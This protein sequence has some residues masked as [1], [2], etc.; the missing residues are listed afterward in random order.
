[1][2]SDAPLLDGLDGVA[3]GAVAGDDD[4]DDGGVALPRGVD[5]LRAVHARQP[6]V[7]DEDVEGELIQ[8]LER[9]FAA[10]GFHHFEAAL[11]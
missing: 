11:G 5:H 6:Q 4:G 8:Q 1:M 7:G 9:L 10:A 3:H 2:K